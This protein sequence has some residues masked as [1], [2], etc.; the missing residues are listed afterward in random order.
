MQIDFADEAL[1]LINQKTGEQTKTVVLVC[2]L[3]CRGLEFDKAMYNAS[4]ENFFG[5]ISEAFFYFG[6]TTPIAIHQRHQG[7][8]YS[9]L[10]EHMPDKHLAHK[11][12]KGYNAAYFL[13]EGHWLA[14]TPLPQS[15]PSSIARST[16]NSRTSP[17]KDFCLSSASMA[18][19]IWRRPVS[20]WLVVHS[21]P[22]R[23]SATCWRRTLTK[24]TGKKLSQTCHRTT[25]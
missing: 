13:E 25:M 16:S 3:P 12:R 14:A 1:W 23:P 6:G 4:M 5:G 8:G 15:N 11:H 20:D 22:T 21:S 7:P 9:T 17:A 18:R 19:S 2:I 10:D 24:L